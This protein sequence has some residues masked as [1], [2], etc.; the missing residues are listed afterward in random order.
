MEPRAL[1]R[2]LEDYDLMPER[3]V[4][5]DE[6]GAALEQLPEEGGDELQCAH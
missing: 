2:S 4:L 3:Q 5:C 1:H 6:C